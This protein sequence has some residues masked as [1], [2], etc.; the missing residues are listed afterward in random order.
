META[1]LLLICIAVFIAIVR[2]AHKQRLLLS[3]SSQ[4][5][6]ELEFLRNEIYTS[7]RRDLRLINRAYLASKSPRQL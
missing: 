7:N 5:L 1:I 6:L 2:N 4:L 3:E